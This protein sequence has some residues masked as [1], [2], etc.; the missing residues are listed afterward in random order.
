[1]SLNHNDEL[2]ENQK[3]SAPTVA[4]M[5]NGGSIEVLDLTGDAVTSETKLLPPIKSNKDQLV[6]LTEVPD[7][8]DVAPLSKPPAKVSP[9][10]T[11]NGKVKVRCIMLY[12]FFYICEQR[13]SLLYIP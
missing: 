6:D 1:M 10:S 5:G 9:T 4:G 2:W 3:R 11:T 13:I 12:R 7:T 8:D